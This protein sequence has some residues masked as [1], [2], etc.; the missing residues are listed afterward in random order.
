M[1]GGLAAAP[2]SGNDHD[3]V[4][5]RAI[6]PL[7]E[8]LEAVPDAMLIVDDGRVRHANG[9]AERL[10]GYARAE[11][12]GMSIET[13]VPVASREDHE[14][15]RIEYQKN[16]HVRHSA[17]EQEIC[18]LRKDGVEI[19]VDVS[20]SPYHIEGRGMVMCVLRDLSPRR[21]AEQ[22]RRAAEEQLRLFEAVIRDAD[23][24]VLITDS[25]DHAAPRVAYVNRAFARM[26]GYAPEELLGQSPLVLSNGVASR[27]QLDRMLAELYAGR[28]F[29]GELEHVRKDGSRFWVHKSITPICDTTGRMMYSA[30][31]LRDVTEERD[32]SS[33]MEESR[34]FLQATID[35]L[36]AHVAVLD[37]EGDVLA[38]N[39][40]WRTFA[41]ANGGHPSAYV[42]WNYFTATEGRPGCKTMP[43]EAAMR[44]IREVI[45]GERTEYY[46]EYLCEGPLSDHWFGLRVTPFAEPAPRRVVAAHADITERKRTEQVNSQRF[47]WKRLI[48][49]LSTRFIDLSSKSGDEAT[50]EAL[51]AICEFL[52]ADRA[53]VFQFGHD[54]RSVRSI[55]A[56][57]G[58]GA[59]PDPAFTAA[60]W[61]GTDSSRRFVN[62]RWRRRVEMI[63]RRLRSGSA[64]HVP[65]V[66]ALPAGSHERTELESSGVRS[67]LC[68]PMV[69][70]QQ[71]MGFVGIDALQHERPW[72]EGDRLSLQTVGEILANAFSRWRTESI[73]RSLV[74]G[75]SASTG[76]A[77]L[78]SLVAA[79]C[80]ALEADYAIVAELVG[81]GSARTLAVHGPKGPLE[82]FSYPLEGSPCASVIQRIAPCLHRKDVARLF[83]DDRLLSELEIEAYAG[84]P[85]V[86]AAGRPMGLVSVLFTRPIHDVE[87]VADMLRVFAARAAAEM[88]RRRKDEQVRV[89][90]QAL[91]LRVAERTTEVRRQATAMDATMEGMAILE[92]MRFTYVNDAHARMYGYA[93]GR[94]LLGKR[95]QE[96]YGSGEIMRFRNEVFPSLKTNGRYRGEFCGLRRDGTTFDV[97]IS[98]TLTDQGHLI[99]CCEDITERKRMQDALSRHRDALRQA[100]ADLA[101]AARLKDEFLA[102]MSHELRTP[103]NAVL[104]MAEVLQENL[105][106]TLNDRQMACVRS[107]DESGRHL[108]AL[109]NDI[110]DLSKIEAGKLELQIGHVDVRVVCEASLRMI[111][112]AAH[113]KQQRLTFV[114]DTALTRVRADER[115]LKQMLV[116]LLGN[117]VKFTPEGGSVGLE[118]YADTD[119]GQVLFTVWD[120]GIGIAAKDQAALFH[121]FTQLDHGMTK[122]HAGTGL[123]LSL[124]RR[125]SELHGG[126]VSVE[127][128]LGQGSRFTIV[129][130]WETTLR[131]GRTTPVP[132]PSIRERRT[133]SLL[134][135]P[136]LEQGPTVL[137][138]DDNEPSLRMLQEWLSM[139]KYRVLVARNGVDAVDVVAAEPVEAVLMD[140]QMPGMDGLS[141]IKAIRKELMR[142]ALPI[143]AMTALAMPGDRERCLS[144]GANEY[145]SKPVSPRHLL[146][147]LRGL[148]QAWPVR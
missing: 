146:V 41:E 148:L 54:A 40:A 107:I 108:L 113:A 73:F 96:L 102:S 18:A 20:L 118:A 71:V 144:A 110:L 70:H 22:A 112:P 8:V 35:A 131:P 99:C 7:V 68:V 63:M 87:L 16:P 127:S 74:Q 137:V 141:A 45:A 50:R 138:V 109:I 61:T 12:L 21:R 90:N 55:H 72:K 60:A 79:L 64:F 52:G 19:P 83:P 77:F 100:N 69:H 10:L 106:G 104:G 49:E 47:A 26:T 34:R 139:N 29:R 84:M 95:W 114:C 9:H 76:D 57:E 48:A 119:S 51:G 17:P 6:V 37:P 111:R 53:Y 103:L 1:H 23:D 66:A 25:R 28:S 126:S 30:A 92:D 80:S 94:E 134:P 65:S 117:A 32:R 14:G 135:I 5:S 36:A 39:A 97:E 85:L 116:N 38:V 143:I 86:D 42:G 3:A 124:V 128:E 129:L 147:L 122:Q 82:D 67:M 89:L 145:V 33:T 78:A 13:L 98:L 101:R 91:E 136:T 44:A 46:H 56:Y 62:E 11:L 81:E 140:I 43:P 123:G 132:P 125:L 120:T 15:A 93:S 121:P 27:A 142:Q 58:P 4:I 105:V 115:R 31:I 24:A 133:S 59:P 75:L 2:S 130:P 88:D